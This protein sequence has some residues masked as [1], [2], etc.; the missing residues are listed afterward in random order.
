MHYVCV[1]REKSYDH[2]NK[3]KK[4]IITEKKYVSIYKE[5]ENLNF[6]N[7]LSSL[8]SGLYN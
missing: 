5:K 6:Q 7:F 2:Y 8:T 3:D 1:T 4:K